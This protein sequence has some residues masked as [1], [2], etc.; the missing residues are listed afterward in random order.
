MPSQRMFTSTL[1]IAG[2]KHFFTYLQIISPLA[3]NLAILCSLQSLLSVLALKNISERKADS[4]QELIGQGIGNLVSGFFSGL[5][6]C[7]TFSRSIL[8][9]Q[10]GGR[11]KLSGM[12]CALMTLVFAVLFSDFVEYLPKAVISGV[13]VILG[14][15]AIDKWAISL[16]Y[17][18]LTGK[19]V[20]SKELLVNAG[21]VL[22]VMLLIFSGNFIMAIGV[23]VL[24]SIVAFL[25]KMRGIL[26]KRIYENQSIPSKNLDSESMILFLSQHHQDIKV[27]ELAGMIYFGSAE[28]LSEV[29][30]QLANSGSVYII[31]DMKKID[32]ID[33]TGAR[34]L[35]KT[36]EILTKQ[37]KNLGFSHLKKG[38]SVW[39]FLESIQFFEKIDPSLIFLDTDRALEYFEDLLIMNYKQKRE[40]IELNLSDFQVFQDLTKDEIAMLKNL[41]LPQIY[42]KGQTIFKQGDP[43]DAM[44]FIAKGSVDILIDIGDTHLPHTKRVQ[45]ITSGTFFGEFAL[46][47][48]GLRTATVIA[49]SDLICYRLSKEAFENL[50]LESSHLSV[51][52]LANISKILSK[53][54]AFINRLISEMER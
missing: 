34:V 2:D 10:E 14:F 25:G 1:T 24:I 16:F 7:G 27:I 19:A 23:G 29:V 33:L 37:G 9:F 36:Y 8:N 22:A 13:L 46:L 38:S 18:I 47:Q 39:P 20:F 4:R 51:T 17:K 43:G 15:S 42:Q 32:D 52:L 21:I 11:T 50:I 28:K 53:R 6:L 3:F 45:S 26:I 41:L 40:D 30:L 48:K 54:L 31:L 5:S 44:Y 12:I 49:S 35:K